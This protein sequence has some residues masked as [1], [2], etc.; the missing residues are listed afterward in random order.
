MGHRDVRWKLGLLGIGIA[1]LASLSTFTQGSLGHGLT[2]RYYANAD[3]TGVPGLTRIE[4]EIGTRVLRARAAELSGAASLSARWHGYLLVERSGAYTFHL[5]SADDVWL[6]IDNELVADARSASF[7]LDTGLHEIDVRY[8]DTQGLR[9]LNLDWAYNSGRRLPVD[10]SVLFPNPSAYWLNDA[11]F[12]SGYLAPLLWSILVLAVTI[13]LGARKIARDFVVDEAPPWARI[14][15]VAT[16]LVSG[17]LA[18]AGIAWGLPDVRGWAADELTPGLIIDG[19]DARF[20]GGWASAYPPF[21]YYLLAVVLLPFQMMAGVGLTDLM[22]THTHAVMFL[23]ERSLTVV[24]AMA[25]IYLVYLSGRTLH[26]SR[27]AGIASALIVGSMPPF[28]Y[29]AKLANLDVP[30]LFWLTFSLLWYIRFVRTRQTAALYGFA[31]TATLAICTKDQ[32]YG[33]YAL[34]AAHILWLRWRPTQAWPGRV[35]WKDPALLGAASAALLA[36]ALVYNL[37]F[38][39]EGFVTHL[40][41]IVGPASYG[42]R[43]ARTLMGHALMA[44]DAVWQLGWSMGWPALALCIGGVV[45]AFRSGRDNTRWLLLPVASY[46]ASFVSVIMYHFDR[47]FLGVAI[48]LAIYGGGALAKLASSGRAATWRR[49]AC[50]ALLLYGVGYGSAPVGLMLNDS[51]Y[52]VEDWARNN[53]DRSQGIALAGFGEYLPRFPHHRTTALRESWEAAQNEQPDIIAINVQFACRARPGPE[54]REA[55]EFYARLN[56]RDNGL[57]EQVLAYRTRPGPAFLGPDSVFQS[58]CENY[59]TNLAKINPEI[60]IFRRVSAIRPRTE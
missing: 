14:G 18:V 2:G 36:F 10:S 51:R 40:E 42:P 35:P 7:F 32:A 12:R 24:I 44:R 54:G 20:S 28:V 11:L 26:G 49:V 48:I 5:R 45:M 57:Y 3:W 46:Y 58:D 33:F 27:M 23:L 25:T 13:G 60:R 56:D 47:F 50:A 53:L 1:L 34:P 29:Y 16:L 4:T 37:L 17:V 30:Y 22:S 21:F 38:N 55:R 9:G 31:L 59:F 52:Y 43:Y 19:L 41:I 8:R 15:L 39:Y 6:I